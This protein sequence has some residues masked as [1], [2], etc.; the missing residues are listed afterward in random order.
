MKCEG[1]LV[2]SYKYNCE[3]AI[4]VCGNKVKVIDNCIKR[5]I[6]TENSK[7]RKGVTEMTKMCGIKLLNMFP[8]QSFSMVCLLHKD[9]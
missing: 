2:R 4:N 8:I 1:I 3:D 7:F 5:S 9:L 6:I